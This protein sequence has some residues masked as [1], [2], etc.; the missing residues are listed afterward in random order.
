[1]ER[2]R[3][4]ITRIDPALRSRIASLKANK[5]IKDNPG[6]VKGSIIKESDSIVDI[7]IDEDEE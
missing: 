3:N 2:V 7:E 4:D 6:T 5:R 1:M